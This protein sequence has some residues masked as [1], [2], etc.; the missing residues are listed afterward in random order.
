M[1]II[2]LLWFVLITGNCAHAQSQLERYT[3]SLESW[4]LSNPAYLETAESFFRKAK[5]AGEQE[6]LAGANYFIASYYLHKENY[7]TARYYL[8]EGLKYK[9]TFKGRKFL[10]LGLSYCWEENYVLGFD[11]LQRSVPYLKDQPMRLGRA[12]NNMAICLKVQ[13]DLDGARRYY[14]LSKEI[15]HGTGQVANE[16]NAT[17]NL[18]LTFDSDEMRDSLKYYIGEALV[19]A[20]KSKNSLSLSGTYSAL[21]G[22]YNGL[23]EYD[24]ALKYVDSAKSH[25]MRLI[26][27]NYRLA[28]ILV[29]ESNAYFGIKDFYNFDKAL[30]ELELLLP[31]IGSDEIRTHYLTNRH[32]LAIHDGDYRRALELYKEAEAIK[33]SLYNGQKFMEISNMKHSLELSEKEREKIALKLQAESLEKEKIKDENEIASKSN[34]I[35]LACVG[36]ALLL[37]IVVLTYNLYR[38]NKAQMVLAERNEQLAEDRAAQKELLI[39]EIHHRIKNNLQLIS[40]MLFIE[41]NQSEN[42]E[43]KETL[44]TTSNRLQSISQLHKSLYANDSFKQVDLREFVEDLASAIQA[45]YSTLEVEHIIQVESFR[46]DV[47]QAITLGLILN[48]LIT[49]AY[50]YAFEIG[51]ENKLQFQGTVKNGILQLQLKDSG[52]QRIDEQNSGSFGFKLIHTLL[53]QLKGTIDFDYQEGNLI[54]IEIR[55]LKRLNEE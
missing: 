39:G 21:S 22:H 43:V 32:R 26:S 5:K 2:W 15:H 11:Y 17:L 45:S 29:H 40:S 37:A 47:D 34:M 36:L 6:H 9:S 31:K 24:V 14:H 50:K 27:K 7:D 19:L 25:A 12:Y 51:A 55:K 44:K 13:K 23:K 16:A 42:E 48:E 46:M 41:A 8:F 33:D 49:N 20:K 28:G 53:K 1:R 3:D 35:I 18:A 4:K 10:C 52:N 54:K 30:D 38:K